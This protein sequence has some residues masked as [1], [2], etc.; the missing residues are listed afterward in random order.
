MPCPGVSTRCVCVLCAGMCCVDK[1]NKAG[2][3]AI[4]L[5]ALSAVKEEDDM[6]V[7]RKLFSQGNVNAKAS[8]VSP[9]QITSNPVYPPQSMLLVCAR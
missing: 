3:T 4:M 1:Q 8:Q 2:Y 9:C 7:V 6:V 5:A